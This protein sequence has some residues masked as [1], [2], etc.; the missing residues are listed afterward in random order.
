MNKVVLN[1]TVLTL[2]LVSLFADISSEML[3][4]ITPIFLTSV[5][6]ASMLNLGII[7]GIAEAIASILKS[8]SGFWSDRIQHRKFFIVSGYSFSAISKPL[9]GLATGWWFV[10]F[11]RGLDR[12][13]KGIRSAPRDALLGDS[14]PPEQLGAAFGWHRMMD[15]TGAVIGPL[16]SILFLSFYKNDLKAIFMWALVPGIVSIVFAMTLKEKRK[17]KK[18]SRPSL[19]WKKLPHSFKKYLLAWT[20]FSIGNSSDVFLLMRAKVSGASTTTVILMYCFYNLTYAI[21]SPYLGG[22]SDRIGRRKTLTFGLLIF[23]LVYFGFIVF[24]SEIALFTL[25]G[26]YG[27]YMAGTDGV[28]KAFAIDLMPSDRKASAVGLLGTLTGLATLF[29]SILAGALWDHVSFKAAFLLGVAASLFAVF[30]LQQ[31]GPETNLEKI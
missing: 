12:T 8:Y 13:G 7:E 14:V 5:L 2:G 17:I 20:V 10:L 21:G 22:L 3:Y 30:L 27:I 6:G 11:A 26:I 29:A 31:I 23:A 1:P 24:D 16:L 18:S 15:T 28:G 19:S 25:F 9:I 4:P